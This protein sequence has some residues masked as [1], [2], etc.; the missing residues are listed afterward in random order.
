MYE[1]RAED[2]NLYRKSIRFLVFLLPHPSSNTAHTATSP[3]CSKSC[4]AHGLSENS[5]EVDLAVDNP[6]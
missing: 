4:Y 5:C 1:I 2:L 3:R 6:S